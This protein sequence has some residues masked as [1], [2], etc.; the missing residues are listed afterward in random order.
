MLLSYLGQQPVEPPY[1]V[2]GQRRTVR[3]FSL[4]I[5]LC[6]RAWA[7]AL[8]AN[9]SMKK[10]VSKDFACSQSEQRFGSIEPKAKL[11]KIYGSKFYIF[12]LFNST[13][14]KNKNFL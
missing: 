6:V 9:F 4:L 7:D 12:F 3:F 2:L 5:G 10:S 11:Q 8:L 1:V 14:S 13:I